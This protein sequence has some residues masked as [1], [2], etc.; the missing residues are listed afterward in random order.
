MITG[1]PAIASISIEQAFDWLNKITAECLEIVG[2]DI[3][4]KEEVT[5]FNEQLKSLAIT[6]RTLQAKSYKLLKQE[7]HIELISMLDKWL[8]HEFQFFE[9]LKKLQNNNPN[10]PKK[11]SGFEDTTL[12]DLFKNNKRLCDEV[13]ATITKD[14]IDKPILLDNNV[15]KNKGALANWMMD[16]SELFFVKEQ[17]EYNEMATILINTFDDLE[18][19]DKTY[20]GGTN[21]TK[22]NAHYNKVQFV[23]VENLKRIKSKSSTSKK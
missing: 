4:S 18:P 12:L 22:V 9:K 15:V 3:E 7:K 20:F 13:I 11:P 1:K 5:D 23:V 21:T 8:E 6:Q 16:V 10:K 17:L 14:C 2:A 19:F